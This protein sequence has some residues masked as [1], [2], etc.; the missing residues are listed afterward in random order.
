[1]LGRLAAYPQCS[2]D[3]RVTEG[4]ASPRGGSVMATRVGRLACTIGVAGSL[5]ACGQEE[6]VYRPP[7]AKDC[8]PFP[9]EL[10]CGT[11]PCPTYESSVASLRRFAESLQGAPCDAVIG[12]C[13]EYRYTY[14]FSAGGSTSMY[15][16]S[17]GVLVAAGT[18]SHHVGGN[19]P[20]VGATLYGS[21]P[22][23]QREVLENVCSP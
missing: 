23:C 15:F 7:V 11:Q 8:A 9:L 12:R 2:A 17:A 19:D 14:I 6:P 16:D 10:F 5:A 18:T 22:P 20:C 13:G 1:M 4:G 3:V 21:I